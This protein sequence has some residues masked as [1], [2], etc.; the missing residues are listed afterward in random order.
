MVYG[1]P[2]LGQQAGIAVASDVI[3]VALFTRYVF[4]VQGGPGRCLISECR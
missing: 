4:A 1:R 2:F 3:E